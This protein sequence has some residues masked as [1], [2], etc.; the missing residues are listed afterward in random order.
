MCKTKTNEQ[1]KT[2][3][4]F[5]SSHSIYSHITQSYIIYSAYRGIH[6]VKISS[7]A[8]SEFTSLH[9]FTVLKTFK[10]WPHTL[11]VVNHSYIQSKQNQFVK[12]IKKCISRPFFVVVVLWLFNLLV[13]QETS[14]TIKNCPSP[15][16]PPTSTF[17]QRVSIYNLTCSFNSKLSNKLLT[18]NLK[19]IWKHWCNLPQNPP[20]TPCCPT[21]LIPEATKCQCSCSHTASSL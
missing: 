12:V 6:F 7:C 20:H 4:L 10:A 11:H 9:S 5:L 3:D 16:R 13:H 2:I 8:A 1:N 18:R 21:Q 14:T 15:R 19:L 17:K